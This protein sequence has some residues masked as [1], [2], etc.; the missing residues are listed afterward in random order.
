MSLNNQERVN[1]VQ[2]Q[3]KNTAG[4]GSSMCAKALDGDEYGR[5]RPGRRLGRLDQSKQ[6]AGQ[7]HAFVCVCVCGGE[8]GGW[9]LQSKTREVAK[10]AI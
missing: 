7:R 3:S 6:R 8:M 5:R 1:Y 4:R 9:W 2:I 10:G